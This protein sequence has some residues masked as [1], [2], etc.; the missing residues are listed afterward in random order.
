[1]GDGAAQEVVERW[2][3]Q[4]VNVLGEWCRESVIAP[5][6]LHKWRLRSRGFDQAQVIAQIVAKETGGAYGDILCRVRRTL[7]QARRGQG[8][9]MVG[10]LDGVFEVAGEVPE[11]VVLCDDVFTSGATMD[12][13]AKSLKEHGV[14]EVRGLVIAKGSVT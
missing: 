6:P 7:P 9:R 5:I 3:R 1:M 11:R 10:D 4:K 13:A 12:A 2:V 14:K 8:E